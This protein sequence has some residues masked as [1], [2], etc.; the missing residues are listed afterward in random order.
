MQ[1]KFDLEDDSDIEV[2]LDLEE[3]GYL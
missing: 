1:M 2:D 3:E